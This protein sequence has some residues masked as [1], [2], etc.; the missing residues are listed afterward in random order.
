MILNLTKSDEN[1]RNHKTLAEEDMLGKITAL[2]AA[3]H[4]ATVVKRFFQRF[5]LFLSMHW[6]KLRELPKLEER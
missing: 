1:P 3:C 5:S 4:G 2:A 6:E